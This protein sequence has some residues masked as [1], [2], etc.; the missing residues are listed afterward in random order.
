MSSILNPFLTG[1]AG[2]VGGG[3]VGAATTAGTT[4]GG[5]TLTDGV[6]RNPPAE[7]VDD[8]L[9]DPSIEMGSGVLKED[10]ETGEGALSRAL[11]ISGGS[12]GFDRNISDSHVVSDG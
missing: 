3:T 11:G 12:G 5:G 4:A 6:D 8:L 9:A 2:A 1:G 7:D 10:P